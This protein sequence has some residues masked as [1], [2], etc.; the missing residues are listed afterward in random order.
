MTA[1]NE[2]KESFWNNHKA[3]K[4]KTTVS[5][6]LE[7]KKEQLYFCSSKLSKLSEEDLQDTF[8]DYTDYVKEWINAEIVCNKF[9]K[10]LYV[11]LGD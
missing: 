7:A 5:G 11:K 9:G 2:L 4:R 8:G 1:Y 6:E 10:H 3:I